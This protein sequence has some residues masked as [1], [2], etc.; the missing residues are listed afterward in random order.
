MTGEEII[1]NG[2]LS[3]AGL[4]LWYLAMQVARIANAMHG[5]IE[6]DEDI[7]D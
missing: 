3:F 6:Q 5:K 7:S 4:G 1:T 2:S